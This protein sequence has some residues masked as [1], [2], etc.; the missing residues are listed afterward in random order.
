[1][2]LEDVLT[3]VKEVYNIPCDG[4]YRPFL[5]R[6]CHAELS[7]KQAVEES[8]GKKKR[9]SPHFEH[10][11]NELFV[12]SLYMR[13]TR[14]RQSRSDIEGILL[15]TR[16]KLRLL[17]GRSDDAFLWDDSRLL[18][19]YRRTSQ[20]PKGKRVRTYIQA[21]D[22][23]GQ[24]GEVVRLWGSPIIYGKDIYYVQREG[25]VYVASRPAGREG[26]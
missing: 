17:R 7:Y 5:E 18:T 21:L 19:L 22:D 11:V 25:R 9:N 16:E 8:A 23:I 2:A 15:D 10:L 1:M 3:R 20:T 12:F 24:D 6:R 13:R 14:V 4:F 26:E